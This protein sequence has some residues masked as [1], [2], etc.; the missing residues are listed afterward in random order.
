MRLPH[1]FLHA[2]L[3][4]AALSAG[5]S[6]QITAAV[7]DARSHGTLGDTVLSLDEAIQL[8]NGSLAFAALSSQEAAQLS[9]VSGVVETIRIDAA[10][11]P[12]IT[13]ERLLSNVIGQH[14]AHVH[15][16]FDGIDGPTGAPVIDA[17]MLPIG[18][19]LR[20]NHAHV[21][22]L[23]IRGGMVGIEFDST[24]HYHPSEFAELHH[25]HLEHQHM[26][27]L[28]V[29]NPQTSGMQAPMMMHEVHIHETQIGI[30]VV[31]D[32]QFGN[33][34]VSG[35]HVEIEECDVGIKVSINSAGGDHLLAMHHS[36][37]GSV[38]NAVVVERVTPT[39]D[40][41][42]RLNF[43]HGSYHAD[44]TAFDIAT[45]TPGLTAVN[46]HHLDV[47]GGVAAGDFALRA[48]TAGGHLALTATECTFW[49][50]AS[51]VAGTSSSLVRLHNDRFEAGA[52]S[53]SLTD[54]S[55]DLLWDTFQSCPIT[56]EAPTTSLPAP[57]AFTGCELV[58]SDLTDSSTGRSVLN[59]CFLGGSVLSNNVQNLRPE[60][61][62]WIG[63]ATV[64]PTN[65]PAGTYVDLQVDLY[66]GTAAAW[67]LGSVLADPITTAI[68]LRFYF[69]LSS[70]IALPGLHLLYSRVR[71]PI[72]AVN[73]LRG[74][75]L[76]AQAVQ[77][78][79]QGQTSLP[80]VFLPMG[81]IFQID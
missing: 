5:L 39:S 10:V 38:G 65:P 78:P 81:T 31:D 72:P 68:P 35:E 17:G 4:G 30:E 6:A 61:A 33:V 47:R 63:R 58:R 41:R 25:V 3:S 66:P 36:H 11:T 16:A 69:D 67:M 80:P 57:I 46:L 70:A 75:S 15:V 24:L 56:I 29:L 23:V 8:A 76:Y 20:T 34:D 52:M 21:D 62:P 1:Q 9:G 77:V 45:S 26:V 14:H 2:A 73:S 19:P 50:P 32:S 64:T 59:G 44:G 71:L 79:T 53:L 74:V 49:A 18:L 27:G 13:L 48:G 55:A 7:N 40:S 60:L 12:T 37:I 28:R 43:L 22:N 54:G 42:W 51:L